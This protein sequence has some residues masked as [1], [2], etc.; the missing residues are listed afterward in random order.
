MPPPFVTSACQAPTSQTPQTQTPVIPQGSPQF[1]QQRMLLPPPLTGAIPAAGVGTG[2]FATV[3]P[4]LLQ[5]TQN[6]TAQV[7]KLIGPPQTDVSQLQWNCWY[8]NDRGDKEHIPKC[9]FQKPAKTKPWIRESS[10]WRSTTS[11][12]AHSHGSKLKADHDLHNVP[13]GLQNRNLS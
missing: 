7:Q 5:T 1:M 10:I 6:P 9:N 8:E 3:P 2:T 11:E 4:L 12:P 13:T